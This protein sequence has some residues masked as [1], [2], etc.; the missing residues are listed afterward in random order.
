MPGDDV[1]LD[2]IYAEVDKRIKAAMD[3][4]VIRADAAIAAAIPPA[5]ER[6]TILRKRG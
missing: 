1:T 4:E 5:K 3:A 6:L 2:E